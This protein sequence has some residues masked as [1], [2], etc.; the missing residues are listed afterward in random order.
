[1]L[2]RVLADVVLAVHVAVVAFLAVGF[3]LIVV[4][5]LRR[6]EWVGNLWFRVGHLVAAVLV[7]AQ[8]WMGRLCPLTVL[9]NHLREQAGQ[10]PY[11][12]FFVA[13]WARQVVFAD[14]ESWVFAVV[15]T[16]F[17]ALLLLSFALPR[18]RERNLDRRAR[19]R[20]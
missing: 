8:A 12:G 3:V 4:G 19:L 5:V 13:Y 9:E 15:Y 14:A 11:P 7:T 6:W 2:F 16:V 18:P 1:M 10:E 17:V 20:V